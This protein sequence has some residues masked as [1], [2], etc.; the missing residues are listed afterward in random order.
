MLDKYW[1]NRKLSRICVK[2][3]IA[4]LNSIEFIL[5]GGE[6]GIKTSC[7]IICVCVTAPQLSTI[8]TM[9]LAFTESIVLLFHGEEERR[10]GLR[11]IRRRQYVLNLNRHGYLIPIVYVNLYNIGD[12]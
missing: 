3:F 5:K 11:C 10:R 12:K 2:Y 4:D 9:N 8:S 6:N 7:L 1:I